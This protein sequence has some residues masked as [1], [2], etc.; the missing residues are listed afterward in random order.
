MTKGYGGQAQ[1]ERFPEPSEEPSEDHESEWGAILSRPTDGRASGSCIW[2]GGKIADSGL[3]QS[4]GPALSWLA[5]LSDCRGTVALGTEAGMGEC[6]VREGRSSSY[7]KCLLRA[8]C[9]LGLPRGTQWVLRPALRAGP[10]VSHLLQ[11][12]R[13]SGSPDP[14]S[15][16]V[17]L[18][19]GLIL[20]EM[21]NRPL[22]A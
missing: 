18:L 3:S 4:R 10:V 11:S 2:P 12:R 22:E 21:A 8:G 6:G 13:T 15:L 14:Q 17:P 7:H 9:V 20:S 19:N 16:F 1:V 5:V